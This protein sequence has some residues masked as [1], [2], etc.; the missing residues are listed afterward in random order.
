MK[1][2]TLD[3]FSEESGMSKEAIRALKKKGIWREKLHWVKAA[4]GRIFINVGAVE[5][6]IEGKVA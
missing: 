4:N 6:W 2:K 3:K 1:W 5:Q